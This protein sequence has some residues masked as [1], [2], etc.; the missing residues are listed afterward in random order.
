MGFPTKI[1]LI[2]RKA[3]EQWYIG[4]PSA[5]A[6][7]MDFTKGETVEWTIA[8]KGHLILSRQIVPPDPVLVEKKTPGRSAQS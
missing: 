5:V 1:Q 4:F 7:A 2:H 8:D 3:S 6:Q